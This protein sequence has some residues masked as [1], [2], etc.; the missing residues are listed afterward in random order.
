MI[1]AVI[2]DLGGVIL[3]GNI[4]I[5]LKKGEKILECKAKQGTNCVFDKKLNLG[6]SSLRASFERVFGKKMFDDEFLP[7]IK[8]WVSN[9]EINEEM[10]AFAKKL[11]KRYQIAILSNSEQSYE[12]KYDKRL[13]KVFSPIIYSHRERMIKPDKEFFEL[14][15]KRLGVKPEESIMIDDAKE[16]IKASKSI[17]M[18]AIQFK[19]LEDLKKQLE[20]HGVRA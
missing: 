8:A 16:N 3:K 9:W 2:F 7:L 15:L 12:E 10:L 19:S 4:E 6:T 1:K 11:G 17:G 20:L 18:H 13:T 5:F 14:A